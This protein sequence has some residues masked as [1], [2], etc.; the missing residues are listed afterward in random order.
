MR[1][2]LN[3]LRRESDCEDAR[4]TNELEIYKVLITISVTLAAVSITAYSIAITVLGSEGTRLRG[5]IDSIVQASNEK[6]RKGEIKD[7]ESAKKEVE[8]AHS[9][10]QKIKAQLSRLSLKNV[11]LVPGLN[12]ALAT[13]I[14]VMGISD[15]PKLVVAN[16]PL[17][18]LQFSTF[19]LLFGT[20]YLV[21]ALSGIEKAAGEP[22]PVTAAQEPTGAAAYYFVDTA[23]EKI[24][25]DWDRKIAYWF[26][27][28]IDKAAREGKIRVV[29]VPAINAEQ[30]VTLYGLT[31][32]RGRGPS[33]EELSL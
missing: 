24:V 12:F 20:L 25:V 30:F 26:D 21:G 15:Y 19:F 22:R 10:T 8:K 1:M 6:L 4:M 17:T 32:K 23:D 14:G 9:E 18:H 33:P 16:G 11:I 27:D 28:S 7:L 3:H 13:L 5:K 2:L 29:A 31:Y